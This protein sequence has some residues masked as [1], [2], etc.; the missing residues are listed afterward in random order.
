MLIFEKLF[1]F[2]VDTL[3]QISPAFIVDQTELGIIKRFGLYKRLASPGLCWKIP[4]IESYETETVVLTTLSLSAQ[5]LTTLDDRSIVISA[6]VA[7][8]ITDI[9]KYLLNMYD[10]EEVLADITMGEIQEKVSQTNYEDIFEVQDAVL[11]LVR[12]KL[13]DFGIKI[14]TVTFIDLGAARSIRL[15][16]DS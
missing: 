1:D 2:V 6:I 8:S 9:A 4:F 3:D 10:S 15:I 7:Y 16:Q 13:R 14:K 12:K 11:P 5:T